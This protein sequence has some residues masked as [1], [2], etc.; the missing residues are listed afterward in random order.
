MMPKD[1]VCE[2]IRTPPSEAQRL[3]DE[4]IAKLDDIAAKLAR[5]DLPHD[6]INGL[7]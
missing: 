6:R 4:L 5:N 3:H 2:P 1:H 7:G